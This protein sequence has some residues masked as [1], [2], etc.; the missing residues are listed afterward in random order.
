[1]LP[2]LGT[3]ESLGDYDSL[4]AGRKDD[5]DIVITNSI[6]KEYVQLAL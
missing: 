4:T 3:N 2:S 5:C 1:M 6:Y